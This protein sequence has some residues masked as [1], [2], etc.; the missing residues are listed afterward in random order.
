MNQPAKLAAYEGLFR[1]TEGASPLHLF[2][3]EL[4]LARRERQLAEVLREFVNVF[5]IRVPDHR[6]DQP[7]VRIRGET[8]MDVFLHHQVVAVVGK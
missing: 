6:D 1:T 2:G 4:S 8:E 3:F 7:L 5:V